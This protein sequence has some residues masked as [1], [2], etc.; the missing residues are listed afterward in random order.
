MDL[1]PRLLR[2]PTAATYCGY[3]AST[4]EK[5]RCR[6]DGPRYVQRSRA[7]FYDL[8]DL[9]EWLATLPRYTSTAERRR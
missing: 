2:T 7:V 5:M 6:G 3:S 8:R 4:F 1:S 9:D